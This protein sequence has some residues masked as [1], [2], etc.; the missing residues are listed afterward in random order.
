MNRK[1]YNEVMDRVIEII[2]DGVVLMSEQE[3]Y[4]YKVKVVKDL[5]NW[6][7][8]FPFMH[9]LPEKKRRI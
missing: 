8:A 4:D 7:N 9:L 5:H 6:V 2:N 1:R 3:E